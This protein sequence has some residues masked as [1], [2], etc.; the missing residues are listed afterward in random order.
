MD[1]V[2]D[3]FLVDLVIVADVFEDDL[4]GVLVNLQVVD[5]EREHAVVCLYVSTHF[6]DL[7]NMVNLSI[8]NFSCVSC[9]D[10]VSVSLS[11]LSLL[12]ELSDHARAHDHLVQLLQRV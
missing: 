4:I 5:L 2:F 11:C 9:Q 3:Y 7:A 10:L 8:R 6:G 1:F 12:C